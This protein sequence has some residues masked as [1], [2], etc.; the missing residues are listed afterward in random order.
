MEDNF[1]RDAFRKQAKVLMASMIAFFI[2]MVS[3]VFCIARYLH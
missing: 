1:V 2:V 3:A